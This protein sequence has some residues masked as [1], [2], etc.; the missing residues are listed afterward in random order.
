M[1]KLFF[2]F[3]TMYVATGCSGTKKESDQLANTEKETTEVKASSP[4]VP[5]WYD[6]E[7]PLIFNVD[8]DYPET[9]I[10]LSDLS[11]ALYIPLATSDNLL[12]RQVGTCNGNEYLLTND[13]IY[14]QEEETSI[15]VFRKDGS[16][17]REICH[18][19]GGPGEYHYISS[20]AVDTLRQEI[21]VQDANL[22]NG[23]TLVYDLEGNLK[24][25]FPN[26]AKEIALLND[27]L[28]INYF[29]YNPGGPRYSVTR[30]EDGSTVKKLPIRFPTKLPHDSHGRLSYGSLIKSPKGVFLSNL[31]NDTI[32]EIRPDLQVLPRLIDISKYPTNFAQIHPTIET[33][34]YLMFYILRCHSYKPRVDE[35]FYI[36]D[37]KEKQIY[38]MTDYPD[39]SYWRLMDDYPH[40]T[41]WTTTQNSHVAVRTRQV[42]ALMQA[43]GKHGDA[44]L[45]RLIETLDEDANPVLQV[46]IFHSV[47]QVKK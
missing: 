25:T 17:V 16:F 11:E 2:F 20:Y 30:K 5:V 21:F 40:I 9:N 29:Q 23:K 35:H 28:L 32:F 47:D 38:K 7:I 33:A 1:K 45:K 3:L 41:N 37:K 24:R 15:F 43:E 34:R 26:R 14:A 13:L 27:S 8:E 44:Q 19:G 39:N 46:M 42:Y 22:R 12:L 36:Y 31:G 4:V 10:R 18:Q 6:G